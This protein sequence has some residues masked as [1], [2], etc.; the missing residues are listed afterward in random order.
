M[1]SVIFELFCIGYLGV[2][3]YFTKLG[4]A[5][6][7]TGVNDVVAHAAVRINGVGQDQV[8]VDLFFGTDITE[9]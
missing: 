8:G 7:R 9:Y 2:I 4:I 6:K 3:K 5:D 1:P